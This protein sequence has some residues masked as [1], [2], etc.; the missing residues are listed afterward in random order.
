MLVVPAASSLA[1]TGMLSWARPRCS[2]IASAA[3]R[4]SSRLSDPRARRTR[5][6]VAGARRGLMGPSYQSSDGECPY[7]IPIGRCTGMAS[8]PVTEEHLL[9]EEG[10]ERARL[11]AH[12]ADVDAAGSAGLGRGQREEHPV[13]RTDRAVEPDRMVDA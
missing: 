8:G 7:R 3:S 13:V 12:A 4:I 6:F 1:S 5:P 11:V 9:A 2:T 10:A